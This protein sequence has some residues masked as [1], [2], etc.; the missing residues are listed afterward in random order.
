MSKIKILVA[1]DHPIVR[2]GL[3]QMLEADPRITVLAE[4]ENGENA[5]RLAEERRPDILLLDINLPGMDGFDVAVEI[6]RKKLPVRIIF[7]TMHEEEEI[8]NEAMDLGASGYLIKES[9]IDDII[10]AVKRVAAGH[11]YI[12]SAIT[13]HLINRRRRAANL[14]GASPGLA[15]L[16][17]AERRILKLIAEQLTSKEIADQLCINYRTVENHRTNIC[18]KLDVHGNNALL[19]FAVRHKSELL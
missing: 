7:L 14:A 2:R 1:D 5:L 4:A 16:T 15:T 11:I 12:S 19:R 3:A 6:A 8:F 17:A 13:S 9:A 10:D 18:R